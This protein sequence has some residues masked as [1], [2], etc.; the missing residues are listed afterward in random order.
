[1]EVNNL[2]KEVA[3]LNYKGELTP[4]GSI[5]TV[6]Y[7]TGKVGRDTNVKIE[8]TFDEGFKDLYDEVI[9]SCGCTKPYI[10]TVS[11]NTQVLEI[12]HNIKSAGKYQKQVTLFDK[13][14]GKKQIIKIV[15]VNE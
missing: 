10:F 12:G 5:I 6:D 11:E 9:A 15:G 7:G 4:Y 8:F 1:M 2:T 14:G 13:S 3:E